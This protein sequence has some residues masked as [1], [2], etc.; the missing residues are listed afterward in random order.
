MAGKAR[1]FP[2]LRPTRRE[3]TPGVYPE[4][5]F[6]ALNGSVTRVAYGNRR[7][8]STL[9]LGFTAISDKQAGEI[10]KLYEK[11]NG[12]WDFIVFYENN[13]LIGLDT[14]KDLYV[15]T[16]ER[17]SGLRW[18]FAEPPVITSIYPGLSDVSC[19]FVAYLDD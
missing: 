7:S 1:D 18:R 19:S 6:T 12:D 11:V 5:Q 14:S 10:L 3:Y 4:T 16:R 13:G 8:Q 17:A 15:Y 2:A 9:E